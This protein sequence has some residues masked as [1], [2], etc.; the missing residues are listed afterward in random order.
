M[1]IL[2]S[3]VNYDSLFCG[4]LMSVLCVFCLILLLIVKPDWMK[5]LVLLAAFACAALAVEYYVAPRPIEYKVSLDDTIG[6]KE[7][8]NKYEVLSRENEIYII[9]EIEND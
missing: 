5:V 8:L 3:F 2:S 4:I 6:A 1:I 9:K 7:F